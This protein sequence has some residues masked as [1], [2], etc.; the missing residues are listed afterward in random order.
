MPQSITPRF[1]LTLTKNNL[2]LIVDA[3]DIL[4][5]D[6]PLQQAACKRLYWRLLSLQKPSGK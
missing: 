1:T 2:Q 4:H 3:L 5:P 6:D